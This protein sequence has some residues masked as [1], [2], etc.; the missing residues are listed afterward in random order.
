MVPPSNNCQGS[1]ER[2]DSCSYCFMSPE[3]KKKRGGGGERKGKK[4]Q[5]S[6]YYLSKKILCSI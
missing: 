2:L 6:L 1:T 5:T 4:A 3:G